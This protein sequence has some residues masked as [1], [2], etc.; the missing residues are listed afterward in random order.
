M[1]ERVFYTVPEG[2]P[3]KMR[4]HNPS[5]KRVLEP[6][7]EYYMTDDDSWIFCKPCA[8]GRERPKG[9]QQVLYAPHEREPLRKKVT[10][11]ERV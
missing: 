10:L 4:C 9:P 11:R 3:V 6:G 1:D 7:D 5:C 8:T 2:F